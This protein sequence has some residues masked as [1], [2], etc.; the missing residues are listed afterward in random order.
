MFF[1]PRAA[2]LQNRSIPSIFPNVFSNRQRQPCKIAPFPQYSL[3][4]FQDKGQ[5]QAAPSAA[6]S[7]LFTPSAR[8]PRRT[9]LACIFFSFRDSF[10]LNLRPCSRKHWKHG[11]R[12]GDR[13]QC[14]FGTE[15]QIAVF[16]S[17]FPTASGNPAKSLHS[18]ST[19]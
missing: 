1:Q 9:L 11:R 12:S 15:G 18:P 8:G 5:G 14:Q 7:A 3:M 13:P 6:R 16:P 2:T 17:V 19:P 10:S 4:F